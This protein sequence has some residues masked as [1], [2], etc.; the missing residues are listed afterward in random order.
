MV[1]TV[2]C[3]PCSLGLMAP[4]TIYRRAAARRGNNLKGL[5]DFFLNAKAE[6]GLDCL[7]CAVFARQQLGLATFEERLVIHRSVFRNQVCGT[8]CALGW[9]VT[10][11][12]AQIRQSRPDS[13]LGSH[14]TVI[15][16]LLSRYSLASR[17]VERWR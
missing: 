13:G 5:K 16:T 15:K 7:I 14:V 8:T 2:L 17:A 6:S 1:L 4:T 10:W 9:V 12:M 3:V 11:L